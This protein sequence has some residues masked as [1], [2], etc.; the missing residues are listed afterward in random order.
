MF[1]RLAPAVLLALAAPVC[2]PAAAEDYPPLQPLLGTTTDVLGAP[3]AWPEGQAKMTSAIVTMLPGQ[4]TGLHRHLAPLFAWVLEG[5]I[6]VTYQDP[7][8]TVRAYRAGEA[9]VE[10]HEVPHEG[11][12]TGAGLLRILVV[13]AGAEGLENTVS[14]P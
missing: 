11:V 1:L 3:I 14:L 7:A 13:F 8:G 5:E 10:A 2:S 6:T 4:S 9:L 12:N